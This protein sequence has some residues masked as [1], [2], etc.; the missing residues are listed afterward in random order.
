MVN[1]LNILTFYFSGGLNLIAAEFSKNQL[2]EVALQRELGWGSNVVNR[3]CFSQWIALSFRLGMDDSYSE[4]VK[5][6]RKWLEQDGPV[7]SRDR[8]GYR[9]SGP[10]SSST[11]SR[12]AEVAFGGDDDDNRRGR[13]RT[14]DDSPGRG[15][16]RSRNQSLN[17]GTSGRFQG[18]KRRRYDY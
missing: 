11:R 9:E 12:R 6:L 4:H 14:R 15:R 18:S 1:T 3:S 10:M 16:S 5:T 8:G 13:G 17:R 2:T 7:P